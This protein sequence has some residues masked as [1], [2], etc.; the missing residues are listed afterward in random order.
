MKKLLLLTFAGLMVSNGLLEAKCANGVCARRR[1]ASANSVRNT[2]PVIKPVKAAAVKAAA[3]KAKAKHV[4]QKT[5]A[6]RLCKNG[7]CRRSR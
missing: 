3:V 4:A 1:P 2:T 7:S 5:T 6:S